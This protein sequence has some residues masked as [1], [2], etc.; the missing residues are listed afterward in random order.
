MKT[1]I[2]AISSQKGGV[3]KTTT[4]VNLAAWLALLENRVLVVDFDPQGSSSRCMGLPPQKLE[5]GGLL[6]LFRCGAL[7][8]LQQEDLSPYIYKTTIKNLHLLPSNIASTEDEIWISQQAV[9]DPDLLKNT[10]DLAIGQ[11]DF[12][13]I[14]APP[15]LSAMPRM[16]LSAADSILVPLQCE[17]MALGTMPR[18]LGLIRDLQKSSNRWLQIEGILMTM[19][20]P[21]IGYSRRLLEQAKSHFQG[22]LFETVIPRDPRLS[23]AIA[24]HRPVVLYDMNS[25]GSLAYRTL[26]QNLQKKY[27]PAPSTQPV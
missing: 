24:A 5:H 26:A 25:P 9:E 21:S 16:A 13:L 23:E 20:D 27:R 6:E 19:Y 4:V 14:D 22:A 12:I 3:G 10:V 1:R 17:E 15:S 7:E 2:I 11:Y 8:L 18:L